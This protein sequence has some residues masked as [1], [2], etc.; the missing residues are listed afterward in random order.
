MNTWR[1]EPTSKAHSRTRGS[2]TP[3]NKAEQKEASHMIEPTKVDM[4]TPVF[5]IRGGAYLLDEH[6]GVFI[7]SAGNYTAKTRGDP[8]AMST[9]L[10]SIADDLDDAVDSKETEEGT[11]H[12]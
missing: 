9:I 12:A 1:Y 6:A 8:R 5:I 3:C 2:L 4:E 11:T 10:R 7:D